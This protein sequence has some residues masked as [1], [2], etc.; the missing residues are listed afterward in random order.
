MKHL[1]P[2]CKTEMLERGNTYVC[3]MND[4]GDCV[5]DAF[6]FNELEFSKN[7]YD[8]SGQVSPRYKES[9][10]YAPLE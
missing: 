8:V 6:E 5:Y 3:P 10:I 2:Y 1:C 7:S 9:Q 4:I